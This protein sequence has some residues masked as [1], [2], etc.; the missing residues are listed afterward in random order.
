MENF[1]EHYALDV[2]EEVV[3]PHSARMEKHDYICRMMQALGYDM[4][5]LMQALEESLKKN[6]EVT[7]CWKVL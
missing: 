6:Q 5:Q 7:V 2:P 3:V 4:E 1:F